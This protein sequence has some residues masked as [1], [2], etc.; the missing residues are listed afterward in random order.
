M[1]QKDLF[2]HALSRFRSA[3]PAGVKTDWSARHAYDIAL[4]LHGCVAMFAPEAA[5]EFVIFFD[6]RNHIVHHVAVSF[7]GSMIDLFGSDAEQRAEDL[8]LDDL[9]VIETLACA[10]PEML[11][12]RLDDWD[13]FSTYWDAPPDF[14]AR[15]IGDI[16]SAANDLVGG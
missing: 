11:F 13:Y 7:S 16:L 3:L 1:N 5:R 12:K 4:A 8:I 14:Q 10:T 9:A 15:L 6:S 2:L